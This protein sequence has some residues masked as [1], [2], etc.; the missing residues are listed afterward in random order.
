VITYVWDWNQRTGAFLQ[1]GLWDSSAEWNYVLGAVL[2]IG[3]I[4]I[5][6]ALVAWVIRTLVS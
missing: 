4:P 3:L 5:P 6:W 1:G 2:A